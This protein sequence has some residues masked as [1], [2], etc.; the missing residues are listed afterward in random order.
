MSERSG[1][2]CAGTAVVDVGKVI[3]AYPA[4]DHLAFIDSISLSTGGPTLNMAVDLRQLGADFPVDVVCAIGDDD[5]G[6]FLRAECA[7]LGIG[8]EHSVTIDGHIT[9]FTD[10]MVER[11]G[12]RRTFFH[13]AGANSV[14]Q[15]PLGALRTSNARILH[16]GSPGLHAAMDRVGDGRNAWVDLLEEGLAQGM[17]TNLEMVTLSPQRQ[18]HLS[19]PCLPYASSVIINE[20]EAGA[21]TGV[22]IDIE[23]PDSPVDW[24]TVT[25]MAMGLIELG[26]RSLA[27]IHTPAGA[28]A[29]DAHGRTWQQGSVRIPRDVVRSTTGA[30]DAFAAGVLFGIHEQWPVD[31]CLRLGAAA[32]AACVMS[33]HTSAGISVAAACLTLAEEFGFRAPDVGPAGAGVSAP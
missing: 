12:G 17:H 20:L 5:H 10:V 32:S 30:G 11:D 14:F 27:V 19:G 33:P 6:A 29:A 1:V 4:L 9:S 18:V 23:T 7:R 8:L 15:I 28:V 3:D 21:L 25:T 13:H 31:Q 22:D 16:V 24:D 26:V 2:L